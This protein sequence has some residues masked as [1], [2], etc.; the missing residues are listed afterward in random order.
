MGF[1]AL[2]GVIFT[3]QVND[4]GATSTV[5]MIHGAGGGGWE[6]DPW[7]PAFE[8]AGW[9]VVAPDLM[10]AEGGLEATT[11]DDYRDQIVEL[12]RE[13]EEGP[14]VL[15]GASMGA[16]L[17]LKAQEEVQAD[18]VVLVNPAPTARFLEGE[19][20]E[21]PPVIDWTSSPLQE[22]INALPDGSLETAEWA[23]ERWRDESGRVL[24][25]LATEVDLQKPEAPALV[26][27]GGADRLVPPGTMLE[28][29]EAFDADVH[30]YRGTSHLGAL[31]GYRADEIAQAT[32]QWLTARLQR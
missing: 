14:L 32:V 20:P 3:S 30:M 7:L 8:E 18:A 31:M 27:L 2:L 21:Y 25:Q 11:F 13:H 26:V 5:V 16:P 10:P 15:V 6:Y 12:A 29:A 1:W 23:H 28:M 19:A 4:D 24:R 17:V 22:T 9:R